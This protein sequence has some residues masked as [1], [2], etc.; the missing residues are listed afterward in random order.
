MYRAVAQDDVGSAWVEGVQAYVVR[1]VDDTRTV[2]KG[3][4]ERIAIVRVT[5][6]TR[7]DGD[8]GRHQFRA[9]PP[10]AI[11][12]AAIQGEVGGTRAVPTAVSAKESLFRGKLDVAM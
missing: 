3:G 9:G 7:I 12:G 10:T 1:A 5:P 11:G 8:G 6:G 4:A 2:G